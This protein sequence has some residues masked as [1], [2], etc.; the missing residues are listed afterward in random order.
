[1][2]RAINISD[3]EAHAL[4]VDSRTMDVVNL[5]GA[6]PAEHENLVIERNSDNVRLGTWLC[7]P[8]SEQIT[9]YAF[10]EFMYII[11]GTIFL[12][13]PDGSQDSFGPGSAFVLPK[14][15]TGVW[16]QEESVLKFFAMIG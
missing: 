5:N 1:M 13:Y 6:P 14:G 16:R 10:D 2:I 8:Y 9:D 11:R 15:F 7:E 3:A 4:L 12:D